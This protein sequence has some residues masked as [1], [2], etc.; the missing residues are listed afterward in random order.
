[1]VKENEP[2]F[3][4]GRSIV[5]SAIL[6][7]LASLP[8]AGC[9]KWSAEEYLDRADER[10]LDADYPGAVS[11]LTQ[12]IRMEPSHPRARYRR[13]LAYEQ[14][15]LMAEAWRDLTDAIRLRP[16]EASPHYDRGVFHFNRDDLDK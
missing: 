7:L 1:M 15:G 3:G 2:Q 5:F 14:M 9:R 8:I 6:L 4:L 10:Y 12:V 16:N 13:A 11:D